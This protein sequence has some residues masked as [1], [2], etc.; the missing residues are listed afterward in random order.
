MYTDLNQTFLSLVYCACMCVYVCIY[1]CIYVCVCVC[2]RARACMHAC[3]YIMYVSVS[4]F[5]CVWEWAIE[6]PST[7]RKELTTGAIH[8]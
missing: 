6:C 2:A 5:L 4:V 7:V 1:V 8:P 3:M